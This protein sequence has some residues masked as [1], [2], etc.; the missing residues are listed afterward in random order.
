MIYGDP[1]ILG[2]GGSGGPTAQDAIL[3]ATFPAGST[4]SATKSGVTVT[5]TL[6]V[7]AADSSLEAALFVFAPA[8]F[9]LTNPWTITAT[10][11]AS[12]ASQSVLITTNKEYEVTIEYLTY[13]Y[14]ASSGICLLATNSSVWSKTNGQGGIYETASYGDSG[15]QMAINDT[16]T[17]WTY[18]LAIQY[19]PNN[20]VSMLDFNG[21]STVSIFVESMI[22]SGSG[23]RGC[24]ALSTTKLEGA[25]VSEPNLH[26]FVGSAICDIASTPVGN[27]VDI[28]VSGYTGQYYLYVGLASGVTQLPSQSFNNSLTGTGEMVVT[29]IGY[30]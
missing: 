24:I 14:R 16:L 18:Y 22:T 6:W 10:D 26:T 27:R 1:I 21:I 25:F 5:P 7:S 30:K 23:V 2:R 20:V 29:A 17:T 8:Q 9:D 4:V 11:G 13:I 12:T 15:L 3:L 28:D 19:A